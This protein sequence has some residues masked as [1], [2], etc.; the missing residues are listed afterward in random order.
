MPNTITSLCLQDLALKMLR[1]TKP[2]S[3]LEVGIGEG[4]FLI[5]LGKRGL[6]G[7]GIDISDQAVA[8]AK[9]NLAQKRLSNIVVEKKNLMDM[10]GRFDVIFAFEVIEHIE[11][12]LKALKKIHDLLKDDGYFI[13]SVPAHQKAW[14]ATDELGGHH[15]R[16]EKTALR[17]KLAVANFRLIYLWSA[18]YPVGNILK[19]LRDWLNQRHIKA[20]QSKGWV[21][22]Q[23]RTK[24][25]GVI[26]IV[27][28]P[29]WV[30]N[31]LFNRFTVLPAL[32]MQRLF[33][34]TDL[35]HSYIVKAKKMERSI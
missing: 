8:K 10:F 25:S 12:D 15:R 28:T 17:E 34:R 26:R 4:Q 30:Y 22:R 33:L 35:G 18:T 11:D 3:F 14:G 19:P 21:D 1:Q 31:L 13:F 23:E 5:I 20:M 2:R 24:Q 16:Y 9:A 27:N 32:L 6:T 29:D 7:Q